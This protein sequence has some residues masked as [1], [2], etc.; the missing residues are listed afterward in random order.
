MKTEPP[1]NFY[2]FVLLIKKNKTV[3][4]ADWSIATSEHIFLWPNET[5]QINLPA[6]TYNPT[7]LKT[8]WLIVSKF[9]LH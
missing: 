9:I 5:R 7:H 2:K 6:E 4:L 8:G 1:K 3:G